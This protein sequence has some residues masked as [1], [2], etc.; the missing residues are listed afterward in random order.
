[1][2]RS[3]QG[4][5][6]KSVPYTNE[7]ITEDVGVRYHLTRDIDDEKHRTILEYISR[8][9]FETKMTGEYAS[10]TVMYDCSSEWYE[11]DMGDLA[12]DP[13]GQMRLHEEPFLG[14]SWWDGMQEICRL[15][16]MRIYYS[17]GRYHFE[18]ISYRDDTTFTRFTYE[19]DGTLVGDETASLDLDFAAL[20]IEPSVGGVYKFLAPLR[21]VQ[22]SIKLDNANLLEG[23]EWKDGDYGQRYVGRIKK[24]SGVQKMWTVLDVNVTS[25]FDPDTLLLYPQ[26]FLN[27][28]CEHSVKLKYSIRIKNIN[29]DTTY[30]LDAIEP[31]G[32][33]T[34]GTWETTE[35]EIEPNIG[36]PF[37]T[38]GYGRYNANNYGYTRHAE[39]SILA[40]TLPGAA[41][42]MFDI[43]ISFRAIHEFNSPVGA[44]IWTTIHANKFWTISNAL[45]NTMR[46]YSVATLADFTNWEEAETDA[47]LVY[48]S[49]NDVANSIRVKVPLAW[50]DTAQHEKSIEIYD[51]TDWK[52][53]ESWSIGGVGDPIPIGQLLVSEIMSL[54]TVPR[55]LYSGAFVSSVPNAENRFQRGTDYYLPLS[56]TRD[57]DVD[58]FQG[59]F[60]QIAKT[61]PPTVT[62]INS[63]IAGGPIAGQTPAVP[64]DPPVPTLYFETNEAITAGATLTEVDIINTLEV[65]VANG[66]TVT[67]VNSTTGDSENVT[68]TQEILPSDTVMHFE[69]NVMA[70][71]YPDGSPIVIQDGDVTIESGGSKYRYDNRLYNGSTHTVP[72]AILDLAALDGLSNQQINNKVKISRN[73]NFGIMLP[74][75]DLGLVGGDYYWYDSTSNEINV[76]TDFEFVDER[77]HID[78]DL[79]R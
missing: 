31:H 22:A 27:L 18:Q 70:Y 63:P 72:V 65:Y 48:T 7:V 42:D 77:I 23:V 35:S 3:G 19:S 5:W 12:A 46:F 68:L 29:S 2:G 14:R 61:T 71:S 4:L 21:S 64:L 40:E 28:I 24:T 13:F 51:G 11:N 47:D 17:K 10:P 43:H 52:R 75:I 36:L 67:I 49:D 9:M 59:E 76:H 79:N 60:L 39:L 41:D 56:C 8:A 33:R 58:T 30:W 38:E 45:T 26:T 1:M 20:E 66:E 25:T 16:N 62:V 50:A 78:I 15:L 69:S 37:G 74:Y 53:S 57:S 6:A 32:F 54:R 34:I 73:G 55:K 44:T